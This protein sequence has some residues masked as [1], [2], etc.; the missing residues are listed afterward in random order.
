[1]DDFD[2]PGGFADLFHFIPHE[3]S[4][5][6]GIGQAGPGPSTQAESRRFQQNRFL[7][8]DEDSRFV[9]EHPDAGRL[10]RM[11]SSLHEKWRAA[12]LSDSE[13]DF[14]MEDVASPNTFE[15]FASELDWRVA[16]WAVKDQIGKNSLD[17]LLSIP[18][19]SY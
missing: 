14:Q 5:P 15:P 12:F 16:Q 9:Q 8:N 6:A 1:V 4:I 17:R 10:I 7:D 2:D 18:G 13:G 11:D 19:V 3:E